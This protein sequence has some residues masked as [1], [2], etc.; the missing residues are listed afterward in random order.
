MF[1][2]GSVKISLK[3]KILLLI[4]ILIT[5]L[6]IGISFSILI[7]WRT[8]EIESRTQSARNVT[9]A[10]SITVLD[11]L[12]YAESGS[13]N[14]EELLETQIKDFL[15]KVEDIKYISILNNNRRIIA[16]SDLTKYNKILSDSISIEISKTDLHISS[17]YESEEYGW[18]IETVFPL[19]IAGKRWGILR[20][21]VDADPLRNKIS[22]L[23]STLF[24]ST[25]L[26]ISITLIVLYLLIGRITGSLKD[27]VKLMDKIDIDSDEIKNQPKRNDEIGFLIQHFDT[28]QKR[29][30]QQRQQLINAQKQIYHAEKLASIGRLASGVAHEINNPLNGIK[31]CVYS[32][33]KDPDNKKQNF[34]YLGLI[35]EGLDHIEII[36]QKL[37]GFAHQQSKVVGTVNVNAGIEKVL[38]LLEYRLT[39]K[40]V[41]ITK[42]LD[43]EL[44]AIYADEQLIQEVLMNLLLNAMDAVTDNGGIR[45]ETGIQTQNHIYITIED[46][47]TGISDE[48]LEKIFDPFYTTK[49]SGEGTGLG[50]SVSLGIVETHG[51]SIQVKSKLENGTTF[52]I[53]LPVKEVK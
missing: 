44:P 20:V 48:D 16:H 27:L 7:E 46:K 51:G 8:L 33:G 41:L 9:K 1:P 50:L 24:Y 6:M 39:Q 29:L 2:I 14:L 23:F 52:K 17:I 22:E 31:S 37:L 3:T 5:V 49:E 19:Q 10:F 26:V 34:E 36:V 30:A 21:G 32:I 11:A 38:Q 15:Q 18:V 53:I 4:G 40:H 35:N 47:G 42:N 25:L 45:I 28:L 12:I 13:S 43:K